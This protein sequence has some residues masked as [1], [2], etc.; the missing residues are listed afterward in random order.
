[1]RFGRHLRTFR[2]EGTLRRAAGVAAFL[3]CASSAAAQSPKVSEDSC[4]VT[5]TDFDGWKAVQMANASVTITIVPQLGGRVMQVEFA[6]HPYL[7]I[8]SQYK[9]K[10][11]PPPD[12]PKDKWFNY[13][14]D[15]IWPMPEGNQD[16]HHWPG[17]IADVLDDGEYKATTL[18]EGKECRVRL[19][20]PADERTGLQYSREISLG[21]DSPEISFHAVMKDSAAHPIEWSMQ[22]VTQYDLSDAQNAATYNHNFWAYTPVN[23]SSA[24]LDGFHVRSGLADDPSFSVENGL[25]NL[26]WLYLQNEV[27]IDSPGDWLAVTDRSSGY[28]MVERFKVH[29]G[30][31]YPGKATVIFY[32]NGPAVEMDAQGMPAIRVNP[33]DAP[34]YMEAEIN[35]P[36]VKLNPGE[37]YAM[38]TEWYPTR[39]G[40]SFQTVSPA[41]L[42]SQALTAAARQGK[43]EIEGAFGV[44]FAGKLEARLFDTEGKFV[45][46]VPVAQAR[47]EKLATLEQTIDAPPA[48]ARMEIHLIDQHGKDRG[49]LAEARI[50]HAS[51]EK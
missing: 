9:G 18:S 29:L 21:A 46:S 26:R 47:P 51:G 27:W 39:T 7:F 25:F 30:A 42:I 23:P 34:F 2:G 1:V 24:Y 22:S 11:I 28:A 50:N 49:L 48:T 37:T 14:G 44:F 6:G 3:L 15:K 12:D 19:E 36:I 32:K 8:N 40:D 33:D 35:S 20:G 41:G 16:E 13:G 10:Y 17:P 43:I 38:D 45:S 31:E 4:R 5:A